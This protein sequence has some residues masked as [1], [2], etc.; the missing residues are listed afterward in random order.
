MINLTHF[1]NQLS[2]HLREHGNVDRD[3]H[4]RVLRAGLRHDRALRPSLVGDRQAPEGAGQP[5]GER[6]RS[7]PNNH[8]QRLCE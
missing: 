2:V 4:D 8:A 3:Y 1:S 5:P 7:F 6:D